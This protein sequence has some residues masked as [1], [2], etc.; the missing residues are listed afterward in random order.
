MSSWEEFDPGFDHGEVD[1]RA[2]NIDGVFSASKISNASGL[3]KAPNVSGQIGSEDFDW[4]SLDPHGTADMRMANLRGQVLGSDGFDW[5]KVDPMGKIVLKANLP[6]NLDSDAFETIDLNG[7]DVRKA[8]CDGVIGDAAFVK[9]VAQEVT[10][11]TPTQQTWRLA[12]LPLVV[13]V[14]TALAK[15]LMA[16]APTANGPLIAG[17]LMALLAFG[18]LY[19][20]LTKILMVKQGQLCFAQFFENGAT[21]VLQSGVQLVASFGT[22]TKFFDVKEDKMS[23]GTVSFVRVRPGFIGT[24]TDN[25]RPVLLLPGQ[26]LYNNANFSLLEIKSVSESYI[27]NGPFHLV[28][29]SPGY[30]GLVSINKRPAILEGGLHFI[31]S[32]G[33]EMKKAPGSDGQTFASVND[34]VITN[35]PISLIR[36]SPGHVGLAICSKQP[37]LLGVGLHFINDPSFEWIG[38]RSTM[39]GHIQNGPMSLVRVRPGHIGLAT[40]NKA[41]VILDAGMHLLVDPS[42]ELVEVKS[43]NDDLI[44]CGP[45]KIIRVGPG[46]LGLSTLNGRP[47]LLQVGMHPRFT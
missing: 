39:D 16:V 7:A 19:A 31:N 10:P 9:L 14:P 3:V 12:I 24:A 26:H 42:F 1:M 11:L 20:V 13:G 25:G 33:F 6:T 2:A 46:M 37:V 18:G 47:L 30:I 27:R 40:I 21:H 28:R 35:G 38:E 34:M 36:V 22:T 8:N 15:P 23:F 29:V 17:A 5:S 44:E 32:P 41:P 43:V 4:R 45:V